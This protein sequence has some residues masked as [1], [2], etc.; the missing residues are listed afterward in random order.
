MKYKN[1]K[2][3]ILSNDVNYNIYNHNSRKAFILRI[4]DGKETKFLSS[5]DMDLKFEVEFFLRILQKKTPKILE[6]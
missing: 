4:S 3:F 1:G 2:R 5:P 6:H